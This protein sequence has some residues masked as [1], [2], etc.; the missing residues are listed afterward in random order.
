M[1]GPREQCKER[2]ASGLS[3]LKAEIWQRPSEKEGEA[4]GR[5]HTPSAQQT[6]VSCFP[7][8]DQCV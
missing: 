8:F 4:E 1:L 5:L 7:V 6:K 2:E 3:T